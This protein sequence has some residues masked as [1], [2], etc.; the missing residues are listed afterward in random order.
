M[1][2]H[3]IL[4]NGSL[5]FM[6]LD[7]FSAWENHDYSEGNLNLLEVDLILII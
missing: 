1:E 7:H 3:L 5:L 2:T 4:R 6:W